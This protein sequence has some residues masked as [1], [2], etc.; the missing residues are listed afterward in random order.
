MP[1]TIEWT[2]ETWNPVT[3][4][5]NIS[6]GCDNCYAEKITNRFKRHPWGQVTLHPGRL[7]FPAKLKTPHRIFLCSMGDLFHSDV[8]WNFIVRVFKEMRGNRQHTF[9]VLTKR[10][11][12][13]AYFSKH[14]NDFMG[15]FG[16]MEGWPPNV[17]AGTSVESQK[18]APRLD[19]LAQVRAAVRFVS[20]EPALG[21]VDFDPWFWRT[22]GNYHGDPESAEEILSYSGSRRTGDLIQELNLRINW[23]IAGGE[24][25][26]GARP[27][28]P[29]WFWNV[30]DQCQAAGVPFFFKQWGSWRET[31]MGD[32]DSHKTGV[33]VLN[34]G[35]QCNPNTD[36]EEMASSANLSVDDFTDQYQPMLRT[37][38]NKVASGAMLESRD[39]KR[40]WKEFPCR[41]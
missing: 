41:Q 9:Q 32:I 20:Y 26:P 24:S 6:P 11:G 30:R 36:V 12:R 21:P 13:M 14:F 29:E 15:D 35:R 39:G 34:D 23:V 1:T 5:T 40:E 37:R 10:P 25:G 38:T 4:C 2:D 18:Y 28:H 19:L 7:A 8:P 27:A 16:G 3:G 17:W 22:V 33:W 31:L